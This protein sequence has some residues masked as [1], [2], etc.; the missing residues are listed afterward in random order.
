M[1]LFDDDEDDDGY[2][3]PSVIHASGKPGYALKYHV[4]C[5]SDRAPALSRPAKPPPFLCFTVPRF[6][7][8]PALESLLALLFAN[9]FWV[10]LWDLL[11]N[12]VFPEENSVQMLSL[13]VGGALLLY[14]SNSLYEPPQKKFKQPQKSDSDVH[15]SATDQKLPFLRE[16]A[17]D[18]PALDVQDGPFVPPRFEPR[19]LTER[20]LANVGAVIIWTG[21]W[22]QIDVNVLPQMCSYH[23]C[24]N[25]EK[26]G[27]FPCAW[28]KI[29]FIFVGL[30][31]MYFT[32]S[33]YTDR[34]VTY[35]KR[36]T[37]MACDGCGFRTSS[38]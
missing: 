11:D 13:V 17:E 6:E 35:V 32:R 30:V 5:Y 26:Y 15:D 3:C 29:L 20:V 22:D 7:F 14:F 21:I 2:E 31:G 37:F 8:L 4:G 12:T 23:S 34:E 16:L 19:R 38:T 1:G 25:C 10:G 27:T 36:N 9:L 18:D 28:Y 24:G 33:L